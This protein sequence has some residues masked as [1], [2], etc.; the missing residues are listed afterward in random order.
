MP[1]D[2]AIGCRF[3]RQ[4]ILSMREGRQASLDGGRI[5]MAQDGGRVGVV[6]RQSKEQCSLCPFETMNRFKGKGSRGRSQRGVG[7]SKIYSRGHVS[8][9]EEQTWKEVRRQNHMTEVE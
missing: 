3:C 8:C 6:D 5:A 4:A 7:D 9:T 2:H 1:G